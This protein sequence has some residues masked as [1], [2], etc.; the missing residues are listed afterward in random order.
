M[1]PLKALKAIYNFLAGD[2][3]I[4]CGVALT[5][6]LLLLIQVVGPPGALRGAT[7]LILVLAVL[8][9]LLLCLWREVRR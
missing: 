5:F 9:V 7:G 2:P 1:T 8:L 6:A 4:L 3:V